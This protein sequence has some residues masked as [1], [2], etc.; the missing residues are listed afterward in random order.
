MCLMVIVRR[1]SY[2]SCHEVN[3]HPTRSLRTVSWLLLSSHGVCSMLSEGVHWDEE[4]VMIQSSFQPVIL[5]GVG[6]HLLAEHR[7]NLV[8]ASKNRIELSFSGC[9]VKL[10]VS[11]KRQE[12]PWWKRI[13]NL[14]GIRM[15]RSLLMRGSDWGSRKPWPLAWVNGFSSEIATDS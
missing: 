10:E 7:T 2:N 5:R 14:R 15:Q 8:S 6:W 13:S 9:Q 11:E 4:L 1:Y 12:Y 3:T